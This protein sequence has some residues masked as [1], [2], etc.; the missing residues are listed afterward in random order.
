[1]DLNG[2]FPKQL[3]EYHAA[4]EGFEDRLDEGRKSPKRS[5]IVIKAVR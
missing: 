5:E 4:V 1:V 2:I 3:R